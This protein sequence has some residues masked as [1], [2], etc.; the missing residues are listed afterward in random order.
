MDFKLSVSKN[1]F[2]SLEGKVYGTGR[3]HPATTFTLSSSCKIPVLFEGLLLFVFSVVTSFLVIIH[4]L[5]ICFF[6]VE[7]TALSCL[8]SIGLPHLEPLLFNN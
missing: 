3:I 7:G 6:H 2:L 4:I 1:S 8:C 5:F